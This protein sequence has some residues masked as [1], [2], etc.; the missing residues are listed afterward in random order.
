MNNGT[1]VPYTFASL[2][3][4]HDMVTQEFINVGVAVYSPETRYLRVRCSS[5]YHRLTKAFGSV[6]GKHYRRLVSRIESSLFDVRDQFVR[7]GLEKLPDSIDAVLALALPKD[8]SS[9]QFSGVGGGLSP[10][11]DETL[12][13]LFDRYVDRYTKREEKEA[14]SD[15]EV[16][17][18][19]K[20]A[21]AGR[22]IVEYIERPKTIKGARWQHEFP[23]SWKNGVWTVCEPVSLDLVEEESI[24]DK[25]HRWEGRI[26]SL[27]EADSSFQSFLMLGE[28]SNPHHRSAYED[29]RAVLGRLP[30][31]H[32]TV[33]ESEASEFANAI[34][35]KIPR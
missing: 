16:L 26:H 13:S 21:L 7:R 15:P 33:S 35:D 2:R 14:R 31:Q 29:A 17:R 28:P 4:V 5:S 9:L 30:K 25:A 11:L 6:D 18:F 24:V 23:W 34:Q 10:N 8:D 1:P 19:F 22:Q 12:D 20:S 32:Q 27:M 3:Y